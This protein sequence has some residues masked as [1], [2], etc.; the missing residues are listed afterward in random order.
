[1]WGTRTGTLSVDDAAIESASVL[2]TINAAA[3]TVY[4]STNGGWFFGLPI[5]PGIGALNSIAMAPSYPNAPVAGNVLVGA[6]A[7]G[8]PGGV[9]LSTNGAATWAALLSFAAG[10]ANMQVCGDAGYAENNTV[11]AGAGTGIWRY[12]VGSSSAWEQIRISAAVTGLSQHGGVLYG[13]WAGVAAGAVG[14]DTFTL[15]GGG[16]ADNGTIAVTVGS[17][18]AT[19]T[20][21]ATVGGI[22]V[23]NIVPITIG[24][25][26]VP[27]TLPLAADT[28]VITCTT[29]GTSGVWTAA[30]ANST[31]VAVSA[32]TVVGA[33]GAAGAYVF[34]MA[35]AA[36]GAGVAAS[37]ADRTLLPW[38]PDYAAAF[39]DSM[40][41]GSAA[42]NFNAAPSAL[43]VAGTDTTTSAWAIDTA[44]VALMAYN[45]EMALA[46]SDLTVPD[47]VP[48]DSVT[49]GSAE[50]NISWTNI[51]N[52]LMW[53]LEICTDPG[54]SQLVLTTGTTYVPPFPPGPTFVVP[55]NSLVAGKDYFAHVRARD[56][57]PGDAIRSQWS[58][59]QRFTVTA[60]ERVEVSYLG[61]Q[62]LGPVPG[63]IDVPLSPGFTWS[64]YA[65]S[66]RYEFQL[67]TD[68]G[69]S[70]ILAEAKVAATGYKYDGT[71]SNATTY[72]WRARGIEP[73]VTDWS[74]VASFTTEKVPVP[75]VVVEPTPIPEPVPPMITPAIIWAIIAIGAILVIA[76][77]VLIVKTRAAPR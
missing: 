8:T 60:G 28:I 44:G 38:V 32:G 43:R 64:P 18:T 19:P 34:T 29:A 63:A 35:N 50:F 25:G 17:L 46:S 68:A 26:A 47:V 65:D 16:A 12:N 9:C 71:L 62:P 27:Y 10:A 42:T 2:Y 55:V 51:S 76:V 23:G 56:Q 14:A 22:G 70:D 52:A 31:T 54:M 59:V 1:M 58:S 48:F 57:M 39:W 21:T 69:F 77:I 61:V 3:G 73:T 20:G 72:F 45:D 40:N 15:Q 13:S 66:T 67:A 74:P 5:N 37:G 33:G 30:T 41:V 24:M 7:G 11:Y 4:A 75:P 36:A 6:A 53:E 49:G